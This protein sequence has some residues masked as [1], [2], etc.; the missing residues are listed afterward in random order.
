[1]NPAYTLSVATPATAFPLTLDEVKSYL[2]VVDA[3]EDAVVEQCYR[4]AI[5][6]AQQAQDRTFLTTTYT[7]KMD[8]FP[9]SDTILLPTSPLQSVSSITYTDYSGA[10]QTLATSVYAVDTSREPPRIT[11]KYAQSW[12]GT[13]GQANDVTVT[14]VAGYASAALVPYSSKLLILQLA[15]DLFENRQ[16]TDANKVDMSVVDGLAAS[17]RVW[18]VA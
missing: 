15:G 10:S 18:T 13:Y 17:G 6:Q 16:P 12:P 9:E 5:E 14:F 1:M 7:M 3:A 8:T 2:R 11:L 4:A